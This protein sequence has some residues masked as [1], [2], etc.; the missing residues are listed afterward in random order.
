MS[1]E[2][3]SRPISTGN[4]GVVV[5]CSIACTAIGRDGVAVD[6]VA[7]AVVMTGDGVITKKVGLLCAAAGL[8]VAG[9]DTVTV[10]EGIA[11][12]WLAVWAGD[13]G[14]SEPPPRTARAMAIN[15]KSEPATKEPRVRTA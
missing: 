7:F 4:E 15:T 14:V 3:R 8:M 2:N 9:N 5:P 10:G 11:D 13:S 1:V 12:A 6:V